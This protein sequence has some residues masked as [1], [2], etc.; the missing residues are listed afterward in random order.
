MSNGRFKITKSEENAELNFASISDEKI[1]EYLSNEARFIDEV[2]S[3]NWPKIYVFF[4]RWAN[5][6]L[7]KGK[8]LGLI[9]RG[10]TFFFARMSGLTIRRNKHMVSR[11]N[12]KGFRPSAGIVIDHVTTT[13]IKHGKEIASKDFKLTVI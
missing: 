8:S 3:S 1:T 9:G 5:R 12:M 6:R 4:A 2:F 13:V 7:A 11:G 10:L